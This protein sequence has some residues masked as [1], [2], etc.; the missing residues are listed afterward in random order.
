MAQSVNHESSGS[1]AAFHARGAI[2]QECYS[3]HL[4]L[5]GEDNLAYFGA[6]TWNRLQEDDGCAIIVFKSRRG[7]RAIRDK[8]V[9][10]TVDPIPSSQLEQFYEQFLSVTSRRLELGIPHDPKPGPLSARAR[11]ET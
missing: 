2:S 3:H 10:L 9:G 5:L 4:I 7:I 11:K 1:Y 6:G 8:L